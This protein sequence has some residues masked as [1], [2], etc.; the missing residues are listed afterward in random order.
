MFYFFGARTILES[1]GGILGVDRVQDTLIPDLALGDQADFA[2]DVRR[3]H[4]AGRVHVCARAI[5]FC[6]PLA[7][8]ASYVLHFC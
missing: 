4:F 6:V 2:A 8:I 5:V 1:Q 7:A 3:G